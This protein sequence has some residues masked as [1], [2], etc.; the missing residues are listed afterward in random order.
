MIHKLKYP[1]FRTAE[2][3]MATPTRFTEQTLTNGS[4]FWNAPVAS[5]RSL[6]LLFQYRLS[7]P[8]LKFPPFSNYVGS[9]ASAKASARVGRLDSRGDVSDVAKF[10]RRSWGWRG[11]RVQSRGALD[12]RGNLELPGVR[13]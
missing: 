9:G 3:G 2:T 1:E 6:F 12:G 11:G 8:R 4:K 10:G 7:A 5:S 13:R